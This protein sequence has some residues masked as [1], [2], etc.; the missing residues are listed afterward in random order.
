[1]AHYAQLDENNEV[2]SVAV[3]ANADMLVNGVES[4]ERGRALLESVTGHARWLQCSYS[5]S[6]RKNYAG[7]G[8]V[9]DTIR[10]AFIPPR[11]FP[12]WV[13]NTDTCR[14]EAP[15]PMPDGLFSEWEWSE[16]K[17]EWVHT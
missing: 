2:I 5:G 10:D 13:L 3:V 16:E 12:S 15:V 7:I 11:P 4:E 14:W 17:K 1:M 6:F 8:H 9:Y